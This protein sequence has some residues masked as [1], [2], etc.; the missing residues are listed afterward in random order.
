MK[1]TQSATAH[2][3]RQNAENTRLHSACQNVQQ[4]LIEAR[5][6]LLEVKSISSI[7]LSTAN[8]EV[9]RLDTLLQ[10]VGNFNVIFTML[11]YIHYV[12]STARPL[13][14]KIEKKL[15]DFH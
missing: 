15:C 5:T 13:G 10:M 3:E 8:H 4:S 14:K 1:T 12:I 2:I 9:K 6:S 11:F 7:E